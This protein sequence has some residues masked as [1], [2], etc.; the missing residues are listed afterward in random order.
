MVEKR[1]IYLNEPFAIVFMKIVVGSTNPSKLE[2]VREA[3]SMYSFL[4]DADVLGVEVSSGVP[5]QPRNMEQ[6]VQGAINRARNAYLQIA[7]DY[8]IGLESGLHK[9][10]LVGYLELTACILYDGKK[11]R[12][13]FS[14]A[15]PLPEKVAALVIEDGL[16]LSQASYQAGLTG[17]PELG[18]AEG[19]IGILTKGRKTRKDYTKDAIIMAMI[20]VENE[21]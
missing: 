16:N 10:P 4:K 15:F 19:I 14:S 12:P 1:E 9:F 3:L 2:A 13:G 21:F 7:G 6:I 18:K 5:A 8:S 17:N 11:V 20:G